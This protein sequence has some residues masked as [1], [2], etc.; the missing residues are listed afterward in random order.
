MKLNKCVAA[1]VVAFALAG[2]SSDEKD[3]Q[4]LIDQARGLWD[5]VMPAPPEQRGG[6]LVF[7]RDTVTACAS[8]LGKAKDLLEK[9]AADYGDTQAWGSQS[10]KTLDMRVRGQA[11]TCN[12]IKHA[13]GW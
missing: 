8:Q 1:L 2:C 9:V 4:A 7:N 13:Q 12:Q 10:T 11:T 5:E 6:N 3:A